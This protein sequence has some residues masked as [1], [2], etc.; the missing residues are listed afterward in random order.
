MEHDYSYECGHQNPG[1]ED[2]LTC[3]VYGDGVYLGS[4][5]MSV[6]INVHTNDNLSARLKDK[7]VP[8]VDTL[9]DKEIH[10]NMPYHDKFSF[11]EA[12][13]DNQDS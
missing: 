7:A 11:L 12:D 1:Q 6:D 13:D 8:L 2:S 4:F 9:I 5:E 3:Q 10:V